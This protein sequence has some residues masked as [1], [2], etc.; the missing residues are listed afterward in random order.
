MSTAAKDAPR[1]ESPDAMHQAWMRASTPNEH[2]ARLMHLVGTWD[3]RT[4][5]W[6]APGAPPQLGTGVMVNTSILG[7]RYVQMAYTSTFMNTPFEGAGVFGYDT[8]AGEYVGTW[9]DSM[10][11]QML[12]HRGAGSPDARTITMSGSFRDPLGRVIRDRNVMTFIDKDA[13]T[14]EMFHT[15][16]DGAERLVGRIE[17]TRRR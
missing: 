4:T 11:T 5:F 17:Y 10:S 1:H 3:A 13:H 14:Y 16:P 6:M 8:V 2:H 7:G 12:V 15:G 9:M